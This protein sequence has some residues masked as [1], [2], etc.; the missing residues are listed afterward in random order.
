[1]GV[2]NV[3]AS[4]HITL[5]AMGIE[6]VTVSVQNVPAGHTHDFIDHIS[7]C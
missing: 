2:L 1:M 6:I 3:P 7:E 5:M 4:I